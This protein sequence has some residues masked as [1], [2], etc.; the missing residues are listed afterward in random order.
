MNF[1]DTVNALSEARQI[2]KVEAEVIIKSVFSIIKKEVKAGGE[3]RIPDFGTFSATER[4]ER[5]GV[6]PQK[7]GTKIT[8]PAKTVAKFKAASSFFGDGK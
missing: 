2:S 3:V 8:I 7:P 5:Q 6:N 4:K 1:K